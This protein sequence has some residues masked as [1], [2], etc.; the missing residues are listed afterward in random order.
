VG[1]KVEMPILS[2]R[3]MPKWNTPTGRARSGEYPD[4]ICEKNFSKAHKKE[5]KESLRTYLKSLEVI[6]GGGQ[7]AAFA[8]LP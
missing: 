5:R 7:E 3:M 8:R 2:M 6:M 4:Q 1:F